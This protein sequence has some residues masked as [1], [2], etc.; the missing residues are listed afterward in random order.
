VQFLILSDLHANWQALEAVL[1]DSAG[2][3]QEIIC[4]GDIVGYNPQPGRVLDWV[5]ASCAA[6]VRG[7][8]DKVVAGV[9]DIEWFNDVAKIAARWTMQVLTKEQLGYLAALEQGP[10]SVHGF[11]IWHGS[12][13]DEDEYLTTAR[14]AAPRFA[15]LQGPLGFFGHTHQQGGFFSKYGMTGK[16]ARTPLSETGYVLELEPDVAYMVNPGSVGQPRDQDPRA[17]YVLYDPA[18][19]LVTF[20]R[21]EY[22]VLETVA[23]IQQAGLPDVLGLRLLSGF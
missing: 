6:V 11:Q 5:R 20:R 23:E 8:H 1:A 18:R 14:E 16:L 22:P 4:C 9:D 21:V 3:Y 2:Q 15:H 19:R 7:N 12:P 13:A 17:A 10:L